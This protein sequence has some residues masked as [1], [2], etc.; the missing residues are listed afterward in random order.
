MDG[1][2]SKCRAGRVGASA[3]GLSIAGQV[4]SVLYGGVNCGA[5]T[6]PLTAENGPSQFFS[7]NL[8]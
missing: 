7:I 8:G 2:L 1:D 3:P 6:A 4:A 5:S